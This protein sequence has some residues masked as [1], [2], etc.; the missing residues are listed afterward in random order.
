MFF[1]H[2]AQYVCSDVKK[3]WEDNIGSLVIQDYADFIA[4]IIGKKY[5]K[6]EQKIIDYRGTRSTK[7][8]T[9]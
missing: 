5:G 4:S 8:T 6:A 9:Q 7:G 1:I 2:E 3:K